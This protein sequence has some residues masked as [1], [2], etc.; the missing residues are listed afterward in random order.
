MTD[1]RARSEAFARDQLALE[2]AR[3]VTSLET[4]LCAIHDE[5][6]EKAAGIA[7]RRVPEGMYHVPEVHRARQIG[8]DIRS[9]KVGQGGENERPITV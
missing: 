9:L 3:F 5:A 1:L 4:L 6:L 8:K 7:D 2:S